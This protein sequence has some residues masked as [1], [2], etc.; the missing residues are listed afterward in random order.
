MTW[1]CLLL[2]REVFL[3]RQAV[4][5]GKIQCAVFF[6]MMFDMSEYGFLG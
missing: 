4:W 6:S 1:E 3:P 5:F 2:S